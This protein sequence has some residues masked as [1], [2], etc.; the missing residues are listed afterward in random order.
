MVLTDT[1][2]YNTSEYG[3]YSDCSI[4]IVSPQQ[5]SCICDM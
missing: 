1:K 3:N 5:E 4:E 2:V